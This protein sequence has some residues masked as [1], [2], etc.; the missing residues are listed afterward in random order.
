M[1]KIL[2]NR[3]CFI[4]LV[5]SVGGLFTIILVMD[6][7]RNGTGMR[8]WANVGGCGAGGGAVSG[9]ASAMWLGKGIQGSILDFEI[10][11]SHSV[12]HAT[13]AGMS[14]L[15]TH[16]IP[17]TANLHVSA[18]DIALSMPLMWKQK[19][20]GG[21]Q[22][23]GWGDLGLTATPKLGMNGQISIPVGISLPTG[24][25]DIHDLDH[26]L[27][28]SD[29]QNGSGGFGFN[30]GL[31]HTFDFEFGMLIAGA[32][33][34][35]NLFYLE[36]TQRKWDEDLGRTKSTSRKL[37]IARTGLFAYQN[38]MGVEK[39]DNVD[40]HAYLGF[41]GDP[42]TH[43]IGFKSSIP[44]GQ[45]G[46]EVEI[47]DTRYSKNDFDYDDDNKLLLDLVYGDTLLQETDS[48][49]FDVYDLNDTTYVIREKKINKQWVSLDL[50]Y[51]M[52]VHNPDYP[53]FWAIHLPI[54]FNTDDGVG[55]NGF[56][57]EVGLKFRAF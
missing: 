3:F 45:D 41:T 4:T 8:P 33:Y 29:M 44:L 38:D 1:K 24:K 5:A 55:F 19:L 25:S 23:A 10:R 54:E 17:I 31:D 53:L 56:T 27:L 21:N 30:L 48:T 46:F 14:L 52:E 26:F 37:S 39:F 13:G 36:T 34:S 2:L 28:T 9:A 51:G 22:T 47:T 6:Q 35:G 43:S 40:A 57:L 15:R 42:I 50:S 7:V 49:K 16:S 20:E 11:S 32:S 18:T 12:V